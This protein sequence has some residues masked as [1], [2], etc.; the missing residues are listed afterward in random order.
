MDVLVLDMLGYGSGVDH[1]DGIRWM[2]YGVKWK[3][4]LFHPGMDRLS[5]PLR[6]P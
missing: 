6:P 3:R 1:L 5:H 2:A 4:Y